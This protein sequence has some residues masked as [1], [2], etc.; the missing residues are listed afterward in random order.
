[1]SKNNNSQIFVLFA[2]EMTVL[3]VFWQKEHFGPLGLG[4][5]VPFN[6]NK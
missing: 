2:I 1:M 3:S 6:N 5:P 4:M